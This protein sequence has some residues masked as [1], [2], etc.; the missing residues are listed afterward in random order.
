MLLD[1]ERQHDELDDQGENEERGQVVTCDLL[2][3]AEDRTE[4]LVDKIHF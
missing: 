4:K 1:T 2:K 3:E